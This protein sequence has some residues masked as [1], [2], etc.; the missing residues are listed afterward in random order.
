MF[1]IKF[2]YPNG[3]EYFLAKFEWYTSKRIR[4]PIFSVEGLRPIKLFENEDIAWAYWKRNGKEISESFSKKGII[5]SIEKQDI[6]A[7]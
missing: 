2:L 7:I 1:K 3:E 5:V 4:Q 6:K